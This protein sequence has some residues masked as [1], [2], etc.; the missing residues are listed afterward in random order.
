[1]LGKGLANGLPLAAAVWAAAL[2]LEAAGP[3]LLLYSGST[4][5]AVSLAAAEAVLERLATP[6]VIASLAGAASALGDTLAI[7]I[8]DSGLDE[9]LVVAGYPGAVVPRPRPASS[10]NG[11]A[12]RLLLVQELLARGIYCLGPMFASAALDGSVLETVRAGI[13]GAFRVL[14]QAV[15]DGDVHRHMRLEPT[16]RIALRS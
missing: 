2:S 15:R 7:A 4:H 11:E 5:E 12:L 8:V 1:M 3:G 6:E 16:D 13:T 14:A 9:Q 10:V